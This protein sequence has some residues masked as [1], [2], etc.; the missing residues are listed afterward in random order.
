MSAQEDIDLLNERG[1]SAI[2][3]ASFGAASL[4]FGYQRETK[5]RLYCLRYADKVTR[6]H[7]PART[8]SHAKREALW[9]R[10]SGIVSVCPEAD[11]DLL[12]VVR[13]VVRDMKA[14]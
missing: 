9:M 8:T 2:K 14:S 11:G 3:H 13:N 6:F 4:V 1:C 10:R 12:E 7:L 5:R